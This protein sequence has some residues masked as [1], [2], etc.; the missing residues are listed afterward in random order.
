MRL[1]NR[2]SEAGRRKWAALVLVAALCAAG[3]ASPNKANIALR[4]QVQTLETHMKDRDAQHAADQ[5]ALAHVT[6]DRT[7]QTLPAAKLDRL[8][9]TSAIIF[10]R[11]TLGEDLDPTKPG[12][13]GFKVAIAPVDQ[14]NDE[15]KASGSITIELFDLAAPQTRLGTWTFDTAQTQSMWLSTPV[16]DGYVLQF[17]WQTPPTHSKLTV[18]ATFTEELT[19]ATFE[20]KTDLTV[21]V[22]T[23]DVATTSP[24]K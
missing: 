16:F 8:F 20:A 9:R 22:P 7:I 14:F 24:A 6:A 2:K 5:A 13:E 10:K 17:P 4:K 15:F 11:L 1:L 18:K 23:A 19:G 21:N 3:C 12:D